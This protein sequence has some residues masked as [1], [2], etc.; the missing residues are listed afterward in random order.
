MQLFVAGQRV[1]FVQ[2]E[3]DHVSKSVFNITVWIYLYLFL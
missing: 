3:G 1:D 2:V